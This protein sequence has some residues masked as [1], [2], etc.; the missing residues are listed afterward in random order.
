MPLLPQRCR[1]RSLWPEAKHRREHRKQAGR[2][3]FAPPSFHFTAPGCVLVPR[4]STN[5]IGIALLVFVNFSDVCRWVFSSTRSASHFP[6]CVL[7]NATSRL[8]VTS[9]GASCASLTIGRP[10][11][12]SSIRRNCPRSPLI[13][14]S[15]LVRI[16]ESDCVYKWIVNAGKFAHGCSLVNR[17]TSGS[18]LHSH[19]PLATITSSSCI[20]RSM[21]ICLPL[22]SRMIDPSAG[23]RRSTGA[24]G[25]TIQSPL[26]GSS[27]SCPSYLTCG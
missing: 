18:F 15:P 16:G 23:P 11:P 5:Q 20:F 8:Q 19:L 21:K 2:D 22:A 7:C 27:A 24:S 10:V 6:G 12:P 13:T 26:Y 4:S 1:R 17:S 25:C 14:S 9:R 3:D